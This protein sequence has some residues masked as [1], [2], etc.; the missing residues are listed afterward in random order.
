MAEIWAPEFD[1]IKGS[2]KP[3]GIATL[4]FG[5]PSGNENAYAN[6]YRLGSSLIL[7]PPQVKLNKPPNPSDSASAAAKADP[8]RD[9]CIFCSLKMKRKLPTSFEPD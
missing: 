8:M 7:M 3:N 5:N 4:A 9:R 2:D 1:S 6:A